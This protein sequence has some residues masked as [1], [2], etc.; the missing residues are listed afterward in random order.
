MRMRPDYPA[1]VDVSAPAG[2]VEGIA[3]IFVTP[4][5]SA[6]A[7]SASKAMATGSDSRGAVD[8]FPISFE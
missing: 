4:N 7:L 3:R 8:L 5:H 2:L 1:T 6:A